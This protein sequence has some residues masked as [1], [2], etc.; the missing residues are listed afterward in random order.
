MVVNRIIP[1]RCNRNRT[2]VGRVA[3]VKDLDRDAPVELVVAGA[4]DVR[5]SA[6]AHELL[7][8][9]AVG[10]QIAGLRWSRHGTG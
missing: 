1:C 4:E 5:H 9:V 3:L 2:C 10:D 8:L 6:A 7:E